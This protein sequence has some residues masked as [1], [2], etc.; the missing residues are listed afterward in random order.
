MRTAIPGPG[1]GWRHT[2]SSGRPISSPNTL[3]SSLNSQRSGSTSSKRMSSGRQPTLWWLLI[4]AAVDV[5]LSTTSGYSVPCT[6]KST[7]PSLAASSSKTR[8]NSSP[9]IFLFCS[10]SVTPASLKRNRSRA[11][12]KIRFILNFSLNVLC[13][14][15]A[16]SF[17]SRPWSTKTQVS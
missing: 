5:P 9:I 8:M 12:T 10:G 2:T 1:N 6:R 3:T 11:S 13:T 4:T 16:S 14:C 17:L 15:S 7:S